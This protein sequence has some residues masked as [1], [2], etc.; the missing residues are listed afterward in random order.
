MTTGGSLFRAWWLGAALTLVCFLL[1]AESFAAVSVYYFH[2]TVRCSDCLLIEQ[3]SAETLRKTFSQELADGRLEWRSVNLDQPENTHFVFDYD[4]S[5][6][7]LVV[8]RGAGEQAV[9]SKMPEAW[10]LVC[11]PAKFCSILSDLV[12]EQLAQPD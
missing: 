4:L 5:A 1:A 9:F 11:Q 3:L 2:R 12:R 8:V 7:E 6:N 10:K